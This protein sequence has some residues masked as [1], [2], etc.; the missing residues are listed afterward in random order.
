MSAPRVEIRE[1]LP[2]DVEELVNNLRHA[3]IEEIRASG[4]LLP[5]EAVQQCVALSAPCWAAVINGEL[6][7]IF[8][9][10]PI[11]LIGPIGTP[12]LLG[13]P[14]MDRHP[15]TVISTSR[16]YLALIQAA[17]PQLVNWVD[18]RNTRSIRW[19]KALGFNFHP[20]APYGP[21]GLPFHRFDWGF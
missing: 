15:R 12:W 14:V 17:Y 5:I 4:D 9:A 3:D 21:R 13:T 20:A 10:A 2:G 16:P 11:S 8:G 19:L 7:A 1:V 6:A 18:V